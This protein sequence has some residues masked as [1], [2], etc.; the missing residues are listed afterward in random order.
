[1]KQANFCVGSKTRKLYREKWGDVGYF[2]FETNT[3]HI[4]A[5]QKNF[6][7]TFFKNTNKESHFVVDQ[8]KLVRKNLSKCFIGASRWKEFRLTCSTAH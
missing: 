6:H 5:Y 1:M 2:E 7:P 3:L 8:R 4:L